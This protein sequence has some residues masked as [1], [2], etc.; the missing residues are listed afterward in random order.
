MP[1]FWD[2]PNPYN[3]QWDPNTLTPIGMQGYPTGQHAL[4]YQARAEQLAR[5]KENRLI[6]QGSRYLQQASQ[7]FD[8]YR[9]GGAQALRAG[10]YRD[11][12]QYS[13]QSAGMVEAPDLLAGYRE[14]Q[15]L[16]AERA[17]KKAARRAQVGQIVGGVVTVIGAAV[18]G[19]V[20][21]AVGGLVGAGINAGINK[22]PGAAYGYQDPQLANS[23]ANLSNLAQQYWQSRQPT[24]NGNFDGLTPTNPGDVGVGPQGAGGFFTGPGTGTPGGPAAGQQ[25]GGGALESRLEGGQPGQQ[26]Q[27][28][29]EG[30]GGPGGSQ[31]G[32]GG[33]GGP[34]A[35]QGQGK[36]SGGPGGGGMAGENPMFTGQAGQ[37]GAD[38][39]FTPTALAGA[40]AAIDPLLLPIVTMQFAQEIEQYNSTDVFEDALAE[41]LA[42]LA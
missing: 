33:P 11:Q 38:R 24:Q 25:G 9:P 39:D 21:A 16:A 32:P 34:G 35:G 15:R 23:F 13:L 30:A 10:L 8:V 36:P 22:D 28:G 3:I 40:F 37:F 5:E 27:G 6:G 14:E 26:L 29:Q 4:N 19:P 17:R 2:A 31:G 20:G 7:I 12:A 18:G 41:R 1:T 42:V